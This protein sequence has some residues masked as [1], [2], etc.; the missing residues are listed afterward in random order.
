M[1]TRGLAR[2]RCAGTLTG[3]LLPSPCSSTSAASSP[4]HVLLPRYVL[5]SAAVARS[6]PWA[7]PR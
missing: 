7:R 2:R 6:S 5:A 3:A 1:A 4:A